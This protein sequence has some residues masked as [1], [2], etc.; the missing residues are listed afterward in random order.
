MT[1]FQDYYHQLGALFYHSSR[2]CPIGALAPREAR[3]RGKGDSLELCS[4]C[5]AIH[6]Q[7]QAECERTERVFQKPSR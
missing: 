7:Q 3:L 5:M 2:D 4:E 6:E 1:V